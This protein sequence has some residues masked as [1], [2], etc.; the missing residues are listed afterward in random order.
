[1]SKEVHAVH[2]YYRLFMAYE[3]EPVKHRKCTHNFERSH[4]AYLDVRLKVRNKTYCMSAGNPKKS[5]KASLTYICP[6][7]RLD[8]FFAQE[9]RSNSSRVAPSR[10]RPI[11][12]NR[13]SGKHFDPPHSSPEIYLGKYTWNTDTWMY[14]QKLSIE[15]LVSN[16][17]NTTV[18]TSCFTISVSLPTVLYLLKFEGKATFLN[19]IQFLTDPL[20]K[21]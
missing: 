10:P 20:H 15:Q 11:G 9:Q 18:F 1:M 8:K 17:Y 19:L 2:C 7:R 13:K 16:L 14:R 6:D 5:R 3:T 21:P 4:K 12:Q